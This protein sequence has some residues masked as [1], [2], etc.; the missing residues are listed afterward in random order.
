M[1]V[2]I[3][4][5]NTTRGTSSVRERERERLCCLMSTE[6]SRPI[7]DGDEWE[8]GER[9]VKARN[10][11]QLERPRLPCTA[12]RTANYPALCSDPLHHTVAV[13]TAMQ[14]KDIIR[15][16][17]I[18]KQLKQKRSNSQAQLHLPAVDLFWTTSL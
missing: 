17:A 15:N 4:H 3:R 18:R 7:R 5:I 14:N 11:R 12:A 13:P 2:N 1:H 16:S 6:A 10:R 8:K 9:R